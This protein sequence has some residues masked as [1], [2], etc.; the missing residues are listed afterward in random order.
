MSENAYPLCKFLAGIGLEKYSSWFEEATRF[1][2]AE[3]VARYLSDAEILQLPRGTDVS[4][5][6]QDLDMETIL[7]AIKALRKKLGL[8]EEG[9]SELL[10]EG[11]AAEEVEAMKKIGPGPWRKLRILG[12]GSSA[13][14][15][16]SSQ[17]VDDLCVW[18]TS[19]SP[20]LRI[21]INYAK[22]TPFEN[23]H[24]RGKMIILHKVPEGYDP[25]E[26]P[27]GEY[28][29]SKRRRWE[30]RMQGQFKTKPTAKAGFGGEMDHDV[31]MIYWSTRWLIEMV[32]AMWR[33]LS[34]WGLDYSLGDGQRS[35]CLWPLRSSHLLVATP[36][37]EE[38][39]DIEDFSTVIKGMSKKKMSAIE[40]DCESTYTVI[41]YSMYFDVLS[42]QLMN[43][44][45]MYD[46]SLKN[47]IGDS[48]FNMVILD[49]AED[50]DQ[51]RHYFMRL[52]VE[53]GF[54]NS[55]FSGQA[56]DEESFQSADES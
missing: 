49:S 40:F 22:A 14:T 9:P 51:K 28:I 36:P 3:D 44:P 50:D 41:E 5:A 23:E 2:N 13:A 38:P 1:D 7:V 46:I 29:S 18:E 37:G 31:E 19:C 26:G 17:D 11:W 20:A 32:L 33:S 8:P 43:M 39:P 15:L 6:P 25:I 27:A 34:T 55:T 48:T 24:F 12:S 10:K 56:D 16:R 45:G 30:L 35:F 21:P 4:E 47:F 52:R 53:P 42:W 54:S